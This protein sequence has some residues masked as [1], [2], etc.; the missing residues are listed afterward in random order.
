MVCLLLDIPSAQ[1]PRVTHNFLLALAISA[2]VFLCDDTPT[3]RYGVTGICCIAFVVLGAWVLGNAC[4]QLVE[5]SGKPGLD[6]LTLAVNVSVR[7][8]QPVIER[9]V[10]G[11]GENLH[12][13]VIAEGVETLGQ[14]AG[15]SGGI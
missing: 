14:Q 5:W 4:T 15:A 9:M 12:L 6:R 10:I 7:Q 8:V 1:S 3:M 13:S 2:L 11:L